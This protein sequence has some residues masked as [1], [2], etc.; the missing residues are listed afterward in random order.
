[1]EHH[2]KRAPWVSPYIIVQDITKAVAFY[3][4]AFGFTVNDVANG[5]D[6]T[7]VHAEMAYQDQLLMFGKEGAFSG[8]AKSPTSSGMESPISLYVYTENVDDFYDNA[9]QNQAEGIIPPADM[10]WG[11]RMC[12]LK[13]PDGYIWCVATQAHA[14]C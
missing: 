4:K 6:D 1:M 11:D 3:Q 13:D 9:I 2:H 8:I 7:P 12:Q 10:F 5:E 14:C